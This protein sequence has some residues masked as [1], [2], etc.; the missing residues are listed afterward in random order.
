MSG[1]MKSPSSERIPGASLDRVIQG[2]SPQV[3][4]GFCTGRQLPARYAQ[5]T[6]ESHPAQ[7][8]F[9][10]PPGVILF[11]RTVSQMD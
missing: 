11:R 1:T 9:S 8:I 6:P 4:S 5:N 2:V 7:V 3:R 10:Y